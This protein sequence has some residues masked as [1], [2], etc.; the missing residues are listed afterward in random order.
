MEFEGRISVPRC[1]R[2]SVSVCVR[3]CV[4]VRVRVRVCVMLSVGAL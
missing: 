2:M 1:L 3:A 4:R